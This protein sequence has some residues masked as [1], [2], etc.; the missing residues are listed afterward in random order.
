M[1]RVIGVSSLVAVVGLAA[2]ASPHQD[3]GVE[4]SSTARSDE[5]SRP[6]QFRSGATQDSGVPPLFQN[7]ACIVVPGDR[8]Y[9]VSDFRNGWLK[10]RHRVSPGGSVVVT[11]YLNPNQLRVVQRDESTKMCTELKP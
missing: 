11:S 9:L 8:I 3:S 6:A 7:G 1:K 4:S 10:V 5:A 2:Y